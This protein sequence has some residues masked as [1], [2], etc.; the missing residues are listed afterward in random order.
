MTILAAH[1]AAP[2]LHQIGVQS[3]CQRDRSYRGSWLRALGQ[4]LLLEV[5][6]VP[7]PAPV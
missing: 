7:P 5:D 3:V 4:D 2:R 6:A 1:P